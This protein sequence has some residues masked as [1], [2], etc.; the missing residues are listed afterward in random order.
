M[1]ITELVQQLLH[2]KDNKQEPEDMYVAIRIPATDLKVYPE[3]SEDS[4]SSVPESEGAHR[5]P[6]EMGI[7]GPGLSGPHHD[8]CRQIT[9][10]TFHLYR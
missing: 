5:K 9:M 8:L 7:A 3:L 6:D 1:V 4:H 10:Q 2:E